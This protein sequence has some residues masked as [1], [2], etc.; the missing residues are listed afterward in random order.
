MAARL[1]RGNDVRP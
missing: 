1:S